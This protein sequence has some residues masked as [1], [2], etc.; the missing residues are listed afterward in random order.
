M[1]AARGFFASRQA[2]QLDTLGG[3]GKAW[4][5][6]RNLTR[7]IGAATSSKLATLHELQTVYGL[8][9]AYNLI[10]VMMVDNYNQALANK[11][12]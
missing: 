12:D 2:I 9:D 1:E 5:E 6:Y 3:S 11:A 7:I 8:E 4:A 10:E